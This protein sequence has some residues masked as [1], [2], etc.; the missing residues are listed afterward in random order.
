MRSNYEEARL[1][2]FLK[3][4]GNFALST[5]P[6]ASK[7]LCPKRKNCTNFVCW[8]SHHTKFSDASERWDYLRTCWPAPSAKSLENPKPVGQPRPHR[9]VFETTINRFLLV[10]NVKAKSERA[11]LF[12]TNRKIRSCVA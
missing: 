4:L 2:A 10:E 7:G 3:G 11:S 5:A 1:K 6:K 9:S 12:L 8:H